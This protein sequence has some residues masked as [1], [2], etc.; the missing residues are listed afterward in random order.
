MYEKVWRPLK[1]N[2]MSGTVGKETPYKILAEIQLGG[3]VR[4]RDTLRREVLCYA[5]SNDG[6]DTQVWVSLHFIS[7]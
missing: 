4:Y 3:E 2:E 1:E 6:V 7:Y 5:Q